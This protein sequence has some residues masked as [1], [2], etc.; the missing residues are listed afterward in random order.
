MQIENHANLLKLIFKIKNSM[1]FYIDGT[2]K[3]RT[4]DA[5]TIRFDFST[6]K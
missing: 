3:A 2:K 6:S 5:A 1:V 4:T